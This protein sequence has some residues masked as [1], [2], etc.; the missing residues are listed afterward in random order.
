MEGGSRMTTT[1][2]LS[3]WDKLRLEFGLHVLGSVGSLLLDSE[4][5]LRE[6]QREDE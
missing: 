3:D 1:P 6:V 4:A 2:P 5:L